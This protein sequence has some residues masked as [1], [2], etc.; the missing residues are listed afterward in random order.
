MQTIRTLAVL[1]FS[2]AFSWAAP[3]SAAQGGKPQNPPAKGKEKPADKPK[4]QGKTDPKKD[5]T[6]DLVQVDG[7]WYT[8]EEKEKLDKGWKRLDLDWIPAEEVANI[9]KGMFKINGTWATGAEADEYHS[10][11][12]TPWEIPTKHFLVVTPIPRAQALELAKH[13]ETTYDIVARTVG[14]EPKLAPRQHL[15]VRIFGGIEAGNEF[16][17]GAQGESAHHTSVFPGYVAD[18]DSEAPA[19]AI[20]DGE[21]GKSFGFSYNYVGHAVAHKVLELVIPEIDKAPQWLIEGICGYAD[22]YFS[23][24]MRDWAI[25]N[26]VRRGGVPRI[27]NFAKRFGLS[28][29]DP[30]GS[31]TKLHEAAIIVAYYATTSDKADEALFKKAMTSLPKAREREA[32]IDKLLE[33][34]DDLEK[35]LKKFANL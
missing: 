28:A 7:E 27:N 19:V 35:K 15:K 13:A 1:A 23:P 20:F 29:D 14:M 17:Q 26:L 10:K 32:A 16:A 30:D 8:K 9:E 31:Q 11:E 2:L 6:K 25:S 24:Q 21:K 34:S 4:D 18:W 3:P 33:K 22:R 5:P 12:S